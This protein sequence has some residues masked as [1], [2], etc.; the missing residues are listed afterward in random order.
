LFD[1]DLAI[2][3]DIRRGD[4]E[5]F[6]R[7]VDR[8]KAKLYGVLCKMLGDSQLAEELAQETFIKAYRGLENYRGEASFSTWL[9]QIGIH[10][11]RDHLR[12][13]RRERQLRLVSLDAESET[14]LR[15]AELPDRRPGS[16]PASPLDEAE[17]ARMIQS[18]LD[19]L[20]P[21]YREVLLLKHRESWPY[22]RIAETTGETVGTLKVRAH[23]ARKLLKEELE[24]LGWEFGVERRTAAR[25]RAAPQEEVGHAGHD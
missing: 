19:R 13:V 25:R 9:V 22:E 3:S 2:I 4:T 8:H 1:S 6:R 15:W 23:R 12:R 10:T 21:E 5:A 24:G 16:D 18:A 14:T 11:A 17:A 20:P 7:L